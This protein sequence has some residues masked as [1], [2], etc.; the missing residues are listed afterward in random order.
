MGKESVLAPLWGRVREGVVG[1]NLPH[2]YG[3]VAH[4]LRVRGE[5][6]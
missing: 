2:W 6:G 3:L 4:T 1:I 5:G